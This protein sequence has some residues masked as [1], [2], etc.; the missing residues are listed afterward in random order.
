MFGDQ[1]G[2]LGCSNTIVWFPGVVSI[3]VAFSFHIEGELLAMDQGLEY[4]LNDVL[5]EVVD[6]DRWLRKRK[7]LQ[8]KERHNIWFEE[9]LVG[10]VMDLL[11]LPGLGDLNLVGPSANVLD[12]FK[13]S[14]AKIF[15]FLQ[16]SFGSKVL[17]IKPNMLTLLVWFMIA[18][19]L[20]VLL[21]HASL[22]IFESKLNLLEGLLELRSLFGS[23]RHVHLSAQVIA[24]IRM[25][26]IN[27]HERRDTCREV[28]LVIVAEL[29]AP[30]P[31]VPIVLV[32]GAPDLQV[33]IKLLVVALG[34]AF[35]LRVISRGQATLNTFELV[36][37]LGGLGDKLRSAFSDKVAGHAKVGVCTI[38]K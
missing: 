29:R 37:R 2:L 31:F 24:I 6:D 16:Q 34:L 25:L 1:S 15:E 4:L 26:A 36:Q 10:S 14:K 22:C 3:A 21:F 8:R 32:V 28:H 23:S 17:T 13:W 19:V 11:L 33:C 27:R 30:Q 5:N 38:V 7:Y 35:G 9:L 20:I 12:D 18:Y